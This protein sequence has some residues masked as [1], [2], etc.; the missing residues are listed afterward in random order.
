MEMNDARKYPGGLP[1]G[2]TMAGRN[3]AQSPG[4]FA[5]PRGRQT[6]DESLAI[7]ALA[8][9][10][11]DQQMERRC[12]RDFEWQ[13]VRDLEGLRI[14]AGPGRC[15]SEDVFR[16]R[17]LDRDF[18]GLRTAL[19]AAAHIL[20]SLGPPAWLAACRRGLSQRYNLQHGMVEFCSTIGWLFRI[21][22]DYPCQLLQLTDPP[23][24]VFMR[25]NASTWRTFQV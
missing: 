3:E 17:E 12:R 16:G 19:F 11:H 20:S 9:L 13:A 22:I 18:G 1:L 5:Q 2:K 15:T 7:D 4:Q 14:D 10:V 21:A 24:S 23:P 25:I 6:L 8:A